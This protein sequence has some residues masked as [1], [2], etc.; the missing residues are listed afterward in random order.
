[1]KNK[2]EIHH[3]RDRQLPKIKQPLSISVGA[4]STNKPDKSMERFKIGTF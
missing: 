3:I 1:L 2:T 4:V